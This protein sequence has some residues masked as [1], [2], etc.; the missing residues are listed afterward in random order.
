MVDDYGHHPEEIRDAFGGARSA[1]PAP[2]DR[3]ISASPGTQTRDHIEEFATAF[4]DA[5]IVIVTSHLTLPAKTQSRVLHECVSAEACAGMGTGM[6]AKRAM[7]TR[8]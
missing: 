2:D 4:H 6:S 8:W 1:Y 3:G 5:E 7:S